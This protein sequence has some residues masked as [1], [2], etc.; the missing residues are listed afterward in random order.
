MIRVLRRNEP[1][2]K[3]ELKGLRVQAYIMLKK[4]LVIL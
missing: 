3:T 2:G 1:E 4:E